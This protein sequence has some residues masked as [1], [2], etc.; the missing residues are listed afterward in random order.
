MTGYEMRICNTCTKT[1][2]HKVKKTNHALHIILSILT[3]GI[4]LI[5]YIAACVETSWYSYE[6][7]CSLCGNAVKRP[8]PSETTKL[9]KNIVGGVC[10]VGLVILYSM[11][12]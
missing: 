3:M 12:E 8:Q 10:L 6:S 9:V 7:T 1:S 5:L 4:W 11:L 2:M